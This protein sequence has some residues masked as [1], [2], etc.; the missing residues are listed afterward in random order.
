MCLLL[1]TAQPAAPAAASKGDV[2]TLQDGRV[3]TAPI[4]KETSEKLWLD[5]GYTV[6]E[7][8]RNQVESIVRAKPDAE[9]VQTKKGDLFRL[10]QNMPERTPKELSRKFG[11][12]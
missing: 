10:A 12:P 2:V 8:P 7:V 11:R 5:L 4:L 9:V 1:A 3:I 6:V